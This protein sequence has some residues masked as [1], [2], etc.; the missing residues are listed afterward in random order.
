MLT[1]NISIKL[2]GGRSISSELMNVNLQTLKVWI[3]SVQPSS[4]RRPSASECWARVELRGFNNDS[5]PW[6]NELEFVSWIFRITGCTHG[7]DPTFGLKT[8]E[9]QINGMLKLG[10]VTVLFD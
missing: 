5:M 4:R 7:N 2:L 8:S 9:F 3:Y 10:C 1:I 6:R